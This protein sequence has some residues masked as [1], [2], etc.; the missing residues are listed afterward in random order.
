MGKFPEE[1]QLLNLSDK[2]FKSDII[3]MFKELNET[4]SK[5]RMS[6]SMRSHQVETMNNEKL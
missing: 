3:N 2:E 5:K 1:T 6:M 4:M